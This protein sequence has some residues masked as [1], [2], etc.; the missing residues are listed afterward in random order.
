MKWK[1]FKI[2]EILSGDFLKK[3]FFFRQRYLAILLLALFFVYIYNGFQSDS[4]RNHITRLQKEITEARYEL[5]DISAEYT[6]LTRPSAIAERLQQQNS[7]IK[8]SNRPPIIIDD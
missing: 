3:E 2:Q 6:Q 1:N 8:Q 4:Q 5:L 7:N